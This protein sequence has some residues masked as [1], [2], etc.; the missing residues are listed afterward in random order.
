MLLDRSRAV[1]R[2]VIEANAADHPD[3][4]VISFESG[5]TW[6]SA[7]VLEQAATAASSLA[8]LGI[9]GH[10]RVAIM[11]P[12]GPEFIRAWW[13]TRF[14]GAAIMPLNPALKGQLLT[15]PLKL[16]GPALV[17]TTPG[18][19]AGLA[20]ELSGQRVVTPE[21]LTGA[22][23]DP[24]SLDRPIELS[25]PEVILMTSGT[26]GPSK[27]WSSTVMQASTTGMY[28]SDGGL[29]PDDRFL[30]DLP[31]FHTAGLGVTSGCVRSGTHVLLRGRPSL[32]RYF[33]IAAREGVTAGFLVGSMSEKLLSTPESPWD[34]AHNVRVMVAAPLPNDLEA[35][36]RRFGIERILTSFGSTETGGPLGSPPGS[37]LPAPGSCGRERPWWGEYKLVDRNGAVVPFG[38][39]G[40]LLLRPS[41]P[42]VRAGHYVNDPAATA[43]AWRDGWFH[44]GDIFRR[45]AD[46]DYFFIER[47]RDSL[48]RRGENISSFEVE[49]EVLRE[50]GVAS[51]A[52]VAVSSTDDVGVEVKVWIVPKDGVT[53]L[54][55]AQMATN[56]A[57]RMPAFM[58]PRYYE[59]TDA[60]PMTPMMK[61]QKFALRDRGNGPR[62][63]DRLKEGA[64]CQPSTF[65]PWSSGSHWAWFSPRTAITT[66]SAAAR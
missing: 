46:G 62:T 7:R 59:L 22:P 44:T 14:L 27:V 58:V 52:C 56:L 17:V 6:D 2:Y 31:L 8:A 5:E 55:F 43:E 10:D 63:W 53:D 47:N 37:G 65:R 11:L 20:S 48:R 33:E 54:D 32:S 42:A 30:V 41:H 29:T 9:T 13:G 57:A 50:P 61:V 39:S 1:I 15:H 49:R 34:R 4:P 24:P 66:C 40:E 45:D 16:A 25:D 35:F 23:A 64:L 3:R 26:T 36:V 60:V 21:E 51:A 28:V 19:A 12:N 18:L 38:A